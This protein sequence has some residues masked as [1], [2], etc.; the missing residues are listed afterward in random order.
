MLA[1]SHQREYVSTK[2]TSITGERLSRN[3]HIDLNKTLNSNPHFIAEKSNS[4]TAKYLK[5]LNTLR[6]PYFITLGVIH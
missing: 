3:R 5:R 1:L 4:K 2:I 6:L